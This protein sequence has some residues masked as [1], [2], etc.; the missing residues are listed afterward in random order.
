[1][2]FSKQVEHIESK[3][4][5]LHFIHISDHD[6]DDQLG[7]EDAMGWNVIRVI[8]CFRYQNEI[9]IDPFQLIPIL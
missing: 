5:Y 3:T 8:S 4:N 6:T 1:M 9:D 7:L 2:N